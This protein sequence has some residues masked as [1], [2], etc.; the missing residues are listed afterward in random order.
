MSAEL[1]H[2]A[3]GGIVQLHDAPA[4]LD[5]DTFDSLFPASQTPS[6]TQA[7]PVAPVAAKPDAPVTPQTPV[8]PAAQ[9]QTGTTDDNFLQG[10]KSVYKTKE[11]AL[12]GLNQKDALVDQLRQRYALVTGIDPITGQPVGAQPQ[13]QAQALDYASNPEKYLDDLYRAAKE[14]GPQ[15]YA[16]VQQKFVMDSLKPLQPVMQR[17]VKDQAVQTASQDVKD[18]GTFLQGPNYD[19]AL[20]SNA[21]LKDAI[22]V[23]EQDSRFYSQ[24]PGLYKTAYFVA[25]GMQLP[26]LLKANATQQTQTQTPPVAPRPTLQSQTPSIPS[27]TARPNLRGGIDG[28]RAVI[29]EMEGKG[30]NLEF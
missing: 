23:A 27:Q 9:P 18:I 13:N 3:P 2:V 7:Q 19:R 14:G 26:D 4:A 22:S 1:E 25:Q 5:D 15:A 12:E 21:Q 16:Q 29:A 30:V 24:L 17:L 20:N 11:A 8:T 10:A 6:A 28:I